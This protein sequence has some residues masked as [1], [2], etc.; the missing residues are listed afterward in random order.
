MIGPIHGMLYLIYLVTVIEVVVRSGSGL[1]TFVGMVVA[2]W[3]PF[4]AFIVEHCVTRRLTSSEEYQRWGRRDTPA[5]SP[6]GQSKPASGRH[7]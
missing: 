6:P 4:L 5:G 1:W 2:G 3:C 7:P